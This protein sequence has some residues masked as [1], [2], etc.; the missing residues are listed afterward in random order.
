MAINKIV[1]VLVQLLAFGV[2]TYS[3]TSQKNV[4]VIIGIVAKLRVNDYLMI[5]YE[6]SRLL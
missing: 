4:L 6:H 1:V 2:P 3:Q 5:L